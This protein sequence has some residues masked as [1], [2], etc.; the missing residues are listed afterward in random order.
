MASPIELGWPGVKG[1]FTSRQGGVS[2]PPFD[3]F[4]LG[5]HV[6]DDPQAVAHN[7]RVLQQQ[8]GRRPVFLNQVH[9]VAVQHVQADTADGAQADACWTDAMDVA[10]VIMV[11]DCLPVL[12]AAPDGSSVAAVH[13]GWR[14]L[15]GQD[16]RGVLEALFEAWP[17][18]RNLPQRSSL[19]AWLGPCIGPTAF[20]VG[21]EVR[22]AFMDADPSAVRH[23]LATPQPG[24]YLADLPGLAR[25]RLHALGVTDISGNDGDPQ[26]CTVSQPA[27]Y[28]SHRRDARVLGS[29]GRLAACIWRA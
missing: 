9:G 6:G 8:L 19:R 16:G 21:A 23:F 27:T 22:A 20:E 4:N 25:D 10:C 1:L 24:K 29:T 12:L 13:A 2:A 3:Q 17:A 11:A 7:R 14:G 18:A 28:F 5:D 26:W 15:V